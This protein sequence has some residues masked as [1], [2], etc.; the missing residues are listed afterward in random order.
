VRQARPHGAPDPEQVDLDG[1]L[2]RVRIDPAHHPGRGDARIR[3]HRIDAAEALDRSHDRGLE[4][5]AIGDVGLEPGGVLADLAR[6]PLEILGLE[7]DERDA[8]A[9]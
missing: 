6:H 3:H 2:E 1:P 5:V 7:A 8:G 4:R 9:A